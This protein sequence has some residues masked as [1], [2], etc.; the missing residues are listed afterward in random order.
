MDYMNW[1]LVLNSNYKNYQMTD[2]EKRLIFKPS[3]SKSKWLRKAKNEPHSVQLITEEL[4]LPDV[5][6]IWVRNRNREHLLT[7][8][9]FENVRVQRLFL[10]D[11]GCH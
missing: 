2:Y 6:R 4:Y 10:E 7:V 8:M 1:Y 3:W 5:H 11:P 9:G